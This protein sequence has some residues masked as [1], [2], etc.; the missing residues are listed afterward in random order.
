MASRA[1]LRL[2]YG[3]RLYERAVEPLAC[4][5]VTRRRELV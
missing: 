2:S 4:W 3:E 1:E 5:G